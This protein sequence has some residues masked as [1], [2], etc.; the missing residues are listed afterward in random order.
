MTVNQNDQPRPDLDAAI[1]AVIPSLTAVSDD[2]AAASLRRTRIALAETAQRRASA[3]AWRWA[4]PAVAFTTV[5]VVLMLWHPRAPSDAMLARIAGAQPSAAPAPLPAAR[6]TAVPPLAVPPRGVRPQRLAHGPRVEA[7]SAPPVDETP[8]PDPLIA[9]A[10][11]VQQIPEEAWQRSVANAEAPLAVAD[12][13]VT[14]I[15]VTPLDT[16]SLDGGSAESVS[17]GEP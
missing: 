7:T 3:G 12:A 4:V 6:P 8:R 1:D 14:P 5:L 17:P 2:A 9:L 16:P 11:A 13:S 10:R 15:D